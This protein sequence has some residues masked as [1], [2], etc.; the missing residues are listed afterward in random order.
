MITGILSAGGGRKRRGSLTSERVPPEFSRLY[1]SLIKNFIQQDRDAIEKDA[2][3]A[4]RSPA[5]TQKY[6]YFLRVTK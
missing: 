1:D 6:P 3:E 4:T 2:S 5:I